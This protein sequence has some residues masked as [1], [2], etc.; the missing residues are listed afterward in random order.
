[1]QASWQDEPIEPGATAAVP[2]VCAA[3]DDPLAPGTTQVV[4]H[5]A[6]VE[7]HDIMQVVTAEVTFEVCGVTG[8]KGCDCARAAL[9]PRTADA[10]TA[11]TVTTIA[12]HRM[13]VSYLRAA[14]MATQPSYASPMTLEIGPGLR[15]Q[16]HPGPSLTR[17][18]SGNQLKQS[19]CN[20]A[21]RRNRFPS[22]AGDI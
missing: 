2:V 10:S 14:A 12:P 13:I 7:L 5:C 15:P 18:C 3:I 11:A 16:R 17:A 22:A 1:V 6:K 19:G 8:V 4:W 9:P 21:S 20:R